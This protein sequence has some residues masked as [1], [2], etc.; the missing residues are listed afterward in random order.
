[1]AGNDNP[2]FAYGL[3]ITALALTLLLPLAINLLVPQQE[4]E[5]EYTEL[6]N[7]LNG[8]YADFTGSA[9]VKEDVWA[10]K[11]IY[12][13][14]TAGGPRGYTSD[15]WLYG[16]E[17]HDYTPTQYSGGPTGYSVTNR[18][19]E[20]EDQDTDDNPDTPPVPVAVNARDLDIYQYSSVGEY[21]AGV[22]VGD[23]YSAVS[24]DV[25]QKSNIFFSPAGKHTEGGRFF[26]EYSGLRYAFSPISSY[27][28]VDDNGDRIELNRNSATCS[29]IWYQY[30]NVAE[31]I[32]G[33]LVVNT[34]GA[35]DGDRGTAY[36]TADTIIQ[37]FNSAN[38]TARHILQFNGVKLNLY[39][40]MD[41]YYLSSGWSIKD[42]FDAGYWAIMITSESADTTAYTTTDYALNPQNIFSTMVDLLTFNLDDYGFSPFL[43]MICSLIV[44]VPFYIGLLV[45]SWGNY[46]MLILEGILL[47]IQAITTAGSW[48]GGLF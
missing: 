41:S 9:P 1:M 24:L 28:G 4:I 16:T 36:I 13:P 30:Y 18:I 2:T 14:Y 45:I 15:G 38:N 31:G 47:A 29:I 27:L 20:Y 5:D 3:L 19:I 10:L 39:I 8:D 22:K 46:P 11:G 44:V 35:G 32:A 40:R 12:T 6:I 21:N 7:D 25:N 48:L 42:C 34:S 23:I 43:A 26:Y 37:S 33:Q 17:V